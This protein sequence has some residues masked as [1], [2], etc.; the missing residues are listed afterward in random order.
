MTTTS[1]TSSKCWRIQLTLPA[2]SPFATVDACADALGDITDTV[3]TLR[4]DTDDPWS[5]EWVSQN[6]PDMADVKSRLMLAATIA[7]DKLIID[8]L[9]GLRVEEVP[10]IDW[11]SHVYEKFAPFSIGR[12]FIHGSHY[13]APPPAGQTGL[14][15]D[16]ATAFG[17]GEH[18]TTDGCLRALDMLSRRFAARN[19]LDM[20]CGSGILAIAA[21]K[22]WKRPV[23]AVDIDPEAV[24]VTARHAASNRVSR[25]VQAQ[26]GAGYAAPIV[27]AHGPYDLVFANILARPLMLMAR[28]LRRN[29]APG[30]F[31]ILSGLLAKQEAGVL[32]AHRLQGMH[33]AA[34]FSKNGWQ[35]LILQ[36]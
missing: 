26:A 10:E 22:L 30:G 5:V 12:F 28:D 18:E 35:A 25:L 34:R 23:V 2:D 32:A 14:C 33:L 36:G 4:H 13:T 6:E 19:V 15:I 24:H 20:G 31:A 17:S 16:A 29:L 21:A 3:S 9:P 8:C 27:R 11:L 7:G 1:A